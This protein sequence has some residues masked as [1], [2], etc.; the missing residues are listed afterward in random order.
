MRTP[1]T[2]LARSFLTTLHDWRPISALVSVNYIHVSVPMM[3][4]GLVLWMNKLVSAFFPTADLKVTFGILRGY[5]SVPVLL[6]G[7]GRCRGVDGCEG[8]ICVQLNIGCG[9]LVFLGHPM[10]VEEDGAVVGTVADSVV[11]ANVRL[12]GV[13][14]HWSH[15]AQTIPRCSHATVLSHVPHG[16]RRSRYGNV[17]WAFLHTLVLIVLLVRYNMQ[18]GC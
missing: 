3:I 7:A 8:F 10:Q 5:V 9:A 1:L 11:P 6:A 2:F 12:F 4:F 15:D 18:Y 13:G 14:N 17:D 16:A